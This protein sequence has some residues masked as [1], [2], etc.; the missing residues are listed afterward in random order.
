L[1]NERA[2]TTVDLFEPAVLL[3]YAHAFG[4]FGVFGEAAP[5]RRHAE[6]R[7]F[8]GRFLRLLR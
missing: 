4:V 1:K 7:V 5:S 2:T 8:F 3:T 6:E